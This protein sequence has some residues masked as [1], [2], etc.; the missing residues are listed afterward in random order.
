MNHSVQGLFESGK[1]ETKVDLQLPKF[2]LEQTI[3]LES[4]LA[5]LGVKDMFI[6]DLADFSGID[7]S[8]ELFVSKVLQKAYIEITEDGTEAAAATVYDLITSRYILICE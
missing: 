8:R 1:C 2:K 5:T 7:G 4:H 6:P 3:D